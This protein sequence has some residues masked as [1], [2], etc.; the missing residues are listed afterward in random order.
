MYG[1]ET[2]VNQKYILTY[3]VDHIEGLFFK[4]VSVDGV[5]IQEDSQKYNPMLTIKDIASIVEDYK[6]DL[7]A[8]LDEEEIEYD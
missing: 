1:V 4:L 2:K 6:F 8:E 7:S 5:L 3:G